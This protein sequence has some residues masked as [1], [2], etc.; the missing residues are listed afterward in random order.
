MKKKDSP[1]G[2][3]KTVEEEVPGG[4]VWTATKSV[5]FDLPQTVIDF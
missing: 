1:N 5:E 4:V 2:C 3:P